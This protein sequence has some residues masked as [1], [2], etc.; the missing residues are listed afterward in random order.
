ME[1]DP[2]KNKQPA[3][4]IKSFFIIIIPLCFLLNMLP[5]GRHIKGKPNTPNV[6]PQYF[7]TSLKPGD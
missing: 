4:T 2:T 5:C 1:I 7:L 3:K 6:H